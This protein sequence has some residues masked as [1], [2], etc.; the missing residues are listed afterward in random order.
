METNQQYLTRRIDEYCTLKKVEAEHF[1]LRLQQQRET[2]DE[3]RVSNNTFVQ[4]TH[5]VKVIAERE[6]RLDLLKEAALAEH[7]KM[8]ST[9]DMESLKCEDNFSLH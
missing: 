9:A 5:V 7:I 4:N 3:L 1:F 6:T 8:W 2:L